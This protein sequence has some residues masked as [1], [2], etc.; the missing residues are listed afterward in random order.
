MRTDLTLLTQ[1]LLT[2]NRQSATAVYI[3]MNVARSRAVAKVL[4]K[5]HLSKYN[6]EQ[7]EHK[8]GTH[9]ICAVRSGLLRRSRRKYMTVRARDLRTSCALRA[10]RACSQINDSHSSS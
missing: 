10:T 3:E 7:R 8:C 5:I 4:K 9:G 1:C 6:A 2:C